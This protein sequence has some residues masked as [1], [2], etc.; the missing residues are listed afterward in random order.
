MNTVIKVTPE[1]IS[2]LQTLGNFA[3]L[4]DR[5]AIFLPFIF[6]Q[7]SHL[8]AD[9]FEL[10][11]MTDQGMKDWEDLRQLEITNTVMQDVV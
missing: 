7:H 6:V 3:N 11:L 2:F 4:G 10:I 1:I 5:K 8:P 9:E